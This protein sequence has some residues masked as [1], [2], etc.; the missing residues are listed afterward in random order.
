MTVTVQRV[1]QA[2]STVVSPFPQSAFLRFQT[3]AINRDQ[4]AGN[5][6]DVLSEGQ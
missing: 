4:E 6:A 1:I 2:Q 5:P 3:P